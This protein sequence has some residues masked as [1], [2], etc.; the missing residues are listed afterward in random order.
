MGLY[1]VIFL[2][3]SVVG[4]E[5]E[6]RLLNGLRKKFNLSPERAEGLLQKIPVVVKKGIS[7]EEMERYVKAF[8]EIGGRIR[9]EEEP[10]TEEQGILKTSEPEKKLFTGKMATCPQCGFEQ[11]ETD[12]CIKCG[13]VISKYNQYQEMAH[14]YE[15]KIKVREVSE[16]KEGIP[17]ESGGG[18]IGGFFQTTKEAL[19]SP[20]RFFRK[21]GEEEG[22]WSPLIFGIIAGIIGGFG[23]LFW[24]WLII[25]QFFPIGGILLAIPYSLLLTGIIIAMPFMVTFSIFAETS[26]AHLCLM[27][28]GGNKK[29][30]E[31]TFR[32]V[33]Y[34]WSGYLF[35][36]VPFIGSTI[37]WI[38][39]LILIIIGVREGHSISTGKAVLAVLLPFIVMVGLGILAAIFILLFLGG[40]GFFGGVRV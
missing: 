8:Q 14:F 17:W 21:M 19:F 7:K 36:I 31:T 27:I 25:T 4:L 12:E 1:K 38:Y 2:G 34:S 22:Y 30:Y 9:V 6:A 3:L 29:G 40:M 35:G 10:V 13:I 37:G 28:V 24:Q 32:V 5:E 18:V 11:P 26:V 15:D 33:S 23:G 20:T 16:E 39:S